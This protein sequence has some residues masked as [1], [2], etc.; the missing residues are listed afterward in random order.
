MATQEHFHLNPDPC[1]PKLPYDIQLLI[2][3]LAAEDYRLRSVLRAP[4]LTHRALRRQCQKHIFSKIRSQHHIAFLELLKVSPHLASYVRKLD[5]HC[6]SQLNEERKG[7]KFLDKLHYLQSL[8][9]N[10]YINGHL[11][12]FPWKQLN[13]KMA[14]ALVGKLSPQLRSLSICGIV[15]FPVEAFMKLYISSNL[16]SLEIEDLNFPEHG[17]IGRALNVSGTVE[18]CFQAQA[19]AAPPLSKLFAGEMSIQPLKMLY[20]LSLLCQNPLP[21]L[22]FSK[23][24]E[25]SVVWGE[26]QTVRRVLELSNAVET[27]TCS[28]E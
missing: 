11:I 28:C 17:N 8:S 2:V 18:D 23:I 21:T 27:L 5:I 15:G 12:C 19:I 10:N 9:I 25:L 22:D 20:G 14:V 26:S 4:A 13:K 6:L 1:D 24:R 7:H 16:Q 3:D